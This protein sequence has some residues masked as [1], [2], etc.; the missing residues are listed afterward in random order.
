MRYLRHDGSVPIFV[1]PY[2]VENWHDVK[3][4]LP[5][6]KSVNESFDNEYALGDFVDANANNDED[7]TN[8]DEVEVNNDEDEVDYFAQSR[9]TD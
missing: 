2:C 6:A 7:E 5:S 8:Y 9:L 1:H 3:H 4:S